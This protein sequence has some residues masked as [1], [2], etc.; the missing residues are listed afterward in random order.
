MSA[1]DLAQ[2][3]VGTRLPSH[4]PVHPRDPGPV[5]RCVD[6]LQPDPLLDLLAQRS[7]CPA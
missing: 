4:R 7:V 2:I 5:R 6:R 1:I 3:T